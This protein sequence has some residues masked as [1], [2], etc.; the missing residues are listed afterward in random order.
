MIYYTWLTEVDMTKVTAAVDYGGLTK[1]TLVHI[2]D[3]RMRIHSCFQKNVFFSLR[4]N[5][6]ILKLEFRTLKRKY[7]HI[8][9]NFDTYTFS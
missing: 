9:F 4:Y 3:S 1:V 8:Y 2:L 5:Y 7:T 6:K